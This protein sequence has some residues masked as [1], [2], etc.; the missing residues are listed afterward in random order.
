VPASVNITPH[1]PCRSRIQLGNGHMITFDTPKACFNYRTAA[2]VLHDD[3]VLLCRE[4]GSDFW[5]LPGGRCELM[6]SSHEAIR[7]EIREELG[8]D[9]TVE[10]LL[11]I[12]ENFFTL[13][14]RPFHEIGLYFLVTLGSDSPLLDK[15]RLLPFREAIGI[16]LEAR[17]FPLG[18]V[19]S[20]NLL[21]EFLRNGLLRLPSSPQHIIHRDA[22]N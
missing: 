18:Q 20:I 12:A 8:T 1:S 13:G 7:R 21:P 15:A 4:A 2:V 14:D 16:D 3:H 5:F 22:S 17:W 9:G 10:R 11:W 19:S 6:E